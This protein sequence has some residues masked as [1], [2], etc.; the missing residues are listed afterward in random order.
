M[1]GGFRKAASGNPSTMTRFL[2]RLVVITAL[3]ALAAWLKQVLDQAEPPAQGTQAG[4]F[5]AKPPS[6]A[7]TPSR[8]SGGE[9]TRAEPTAAEPTAAEP[10]K[11]ELYERAQQLGVKGRSKMSKAQL[12]RAIEQQG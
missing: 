8:P 2:R 7:P 6:K 12:R 5:V 1:T 4:H 11:A 3:G 9:P 10:T